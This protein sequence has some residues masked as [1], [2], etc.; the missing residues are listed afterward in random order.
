VAEIRGQHFNKRD[1]RIFCPMVTPERLE[2]L[3]QKLAITFR[4]GYY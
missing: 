2:R 1:H 4:I 3:I